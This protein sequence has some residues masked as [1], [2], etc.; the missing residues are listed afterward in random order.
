MK[1][2]ADIARRKEL[3]ASERSRYLEIIHDES[4][5]LNRLLDELFNMARMDVNTF[6]ISKETVQLSSFLQT[7]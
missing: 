2:Y 4:Q 5:R 6:T 1:G 7:I 3:D